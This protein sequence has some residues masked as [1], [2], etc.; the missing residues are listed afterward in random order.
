MATLDSWV[1]RGGPIEELQD[2]VAATCGKL[3]MI[4]V[5]AAE[6][7][8]L[9]STSRDEFDFRV[10]VCTKITATRAY[11]QPEFQ[12]TTIVNAICHPANVELFDLLCR[13][14]QL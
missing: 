7:A 12:N 5:S 3:V 11:P 8:S 9:A 4:T 6:R 10:D 1:A 14:A 2:T 13:K